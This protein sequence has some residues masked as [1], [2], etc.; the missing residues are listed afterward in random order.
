[1]KDAVLWGLVGWQVHVGV[2]HVRVWLSKRQQQRL[3]A[4]A[5]AGARPLAERE[6]DDDIEFKKLEDVA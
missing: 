3:M 2:Q 6:A 5:L 1:M 4:E